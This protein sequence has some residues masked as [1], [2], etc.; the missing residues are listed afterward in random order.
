MHWLLL[1]FCCFF[2]QPEKPQRPASFTDEDFPV[3]S[4]LSQMLKED[5]SEQEK[6]NGECPYNLVVAYDWM[7]RVEHNRKRHESLCALFCTCFFFFFQL[8]Q[9]N[10]FMAWK[11]QISEDTSSFCCLSFWLLSQSL[12]LELV[13]TPKSDQHLISSHNIIPESHNKVTK[14][15]EMI[16]N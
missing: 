4:I 5:K 11:C 10:L 3:D 8:S 1:N 2:Y 6:E 7:G 15:R 16:T 13:L 14:I 12:L 9:L